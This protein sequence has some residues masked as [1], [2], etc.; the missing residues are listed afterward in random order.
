MMEFVADTFSGEFWS[1]NQII[2][3]ALVHSTNHDLYS[4]ESNIL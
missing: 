3:S 2:F 1:S 4:V